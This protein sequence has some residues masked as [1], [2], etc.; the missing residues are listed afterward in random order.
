MRRRIWVYVIAAAAGGLALYPLLDGWAAAAMYQFFGW[1]A[2]VATIVGVRLHHNPR[3]LPWYLLAAGIAAWS[4]G[5]AIWLVYGVTAAAIP[6][7]GVADAFYLTGYL[8]LA[9][10]LTVIAR[11]RVRVP[12]LVT[13]V[14]AMILTI[15]AG[16]LFWVVLVGPYS[17]TSA[18][19][20]E[21]VVAALYPLGDLLLVASLIRLLLPATWKQ[22]SLLLLVGGIAATTV[23][24]VLYLIYV[25]E[26]TG[27]VVVQDILWMFG[28]ALLAASFLHPSMRELSHPA[29]FMRDDLTNG[30]LALLACATLIAPVTLILQHRSGNESYVILS[31]VISAV[32]F[33]LVVVRMAGLVARVQHQATTMSVMARTDPLTGA[34]NRMV[35]DETLEMEMERARRQG[36]VFS[37]VMLDLDRFK[38]YNDRHGHLAGDEHLRRCVAAWRSVLRSIDT[39]TRFGGEEF[40]V[41]LSGS[42]RDESVMVAERLRA[43]IPDGETCSAG[44]AMWD[45]EESI[46]DLVRRADRALYEAKNAGRDRSIASMA[47]LR[48]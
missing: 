21:K 40:A 31:A 26:G 9:G 34:G 23:A 6:F 20:A 4:I 33:M 28:Y 3:P 17:A 45:G 36:T 38:E 16:L 10:G 14:D 39:L 11:N 47:P 25:L 5:D 30:R 8:F 7:P 13:A 18:T 44:V 27:I 46:S 1:A 32:L 19:S 37:I 29:G 43:Q 2:A 22:P 12:G 15:A 35:W 48:L 42:F 24:D 41:L